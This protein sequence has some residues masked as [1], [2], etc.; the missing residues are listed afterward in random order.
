MLRAPVY[1]ASGERMITASL[2]ITLIGAGFLSVVGYY[3]ARG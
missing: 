2:I 1:C 3:V